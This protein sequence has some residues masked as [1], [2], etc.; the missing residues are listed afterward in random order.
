MQEEIR[1]RNTGAAIPIKAS[2]KPRKNNVIKGP[3]ATATDV[4]VGSTSIAKDTGNAPEVGKPKPRGGRKKDAAKKTAVVE[5]DDDDVLE[6]K[7]RLAAYNLDSSP[8]Q[9]SMQTESVAQEVLKK[10]APSKRAAAM[11]G[12][13]TL[14][15]SD[16]DDDMYG[17]EMPAIS[18]DDDDRDFQMVEALKGKKAGAGRK[19]TNANAKATATTNARKRSRAQGIN[20]PSQKLITD[21][22]NAFPE[23]KVRKMRESP[24]DKTSG[25]VLGRAKG[26]VVESEGSIDS[27]SSVNLE[28]ALNE[29]PVARNRP[30][31]ENRSKV[32]YVE[33]GS[34]CAGRIQTCQ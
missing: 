17:E 10:K 26:S 4:A 33:S 22:L 5:S 24:F 28:A 13:S 30:K 34:C 27:L 29:V 18:E 12:K 14:T 9:T 3:V 31:R 15:I 16:D 20:L 6:L 2:K 7:D 19:P 8:D 23:K 32:Q 25:P 21:V 11:K 1:R